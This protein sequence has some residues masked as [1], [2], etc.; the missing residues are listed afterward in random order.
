M[1]NLNSGITDRRHTASTDYT[2]S[3]ETSTQKI[4]VG[5][6]VLSTTDQEADNVRKDI[7]PTKLQDA[8]VLQRE[9]VKADFIDIDTSKAPEE[10]DDDIERLM[11]EIAL[12]EEQEQLEEEGLKSD[13]AEVDSENKMNA[14]ENQLT[15]VAEDQMETNQAIED[16]SKIS[17][18]MIEASDA[19]IEASD[20]LIEAQFN[21]ILNDVGKDQ[22]STLYLSHDK[23]SY[24]DFEA[25]CDVLG[26]DAKQIMENMCKEGH[27]ILTNPTT[28]DLLI[29]AHMKEMTKNAT[30]IFRKGSPTVDITKDMIH[31]VKLSP[32]KL[33]EFKAK[34][35]AGIQIAFKSQRIETPITPQRE[36]KKTKHADDS[37]NE[38]KQRE[39]LD[40]KADANQSAQKTEKVRYV[41]VPD[42]GSDSIRIMMEWFKN[43]EKK[44]DEEHDKLSQIFQ[45]YALKQ[46]A[47]KD[48]YKKGDSLVT[49]R[50]SD[51]LKIS[52]KELQQD[53]EEA[54]R[55][56]LDKLHEKEFEALANKSLSGKERTFVREKFRTI[57]T[58][59]TEVHYETKPKIN[60]PEGI[61]KERLLHTYF[62]TI[63][64]IVVQTAGMKT[65]STQVPQS[66]QLGG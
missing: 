13:L 63:S 28:G 1:D 16:D 19:L 4:Q 55:I 12:M 21:E 7:L 11:A 3:A 38:V 33:E 57:R 15:S 48:D 65:P 37:I 29:P 23:T 26:E 35:T 43:S 8:N 46:E 53:F 17:D 62:E 10:L 49:E 39:S 41:D 45:K 18:A 25:M 24:F 50:K 36:E 54:N 40:K 60:D 61:E 14:T 44:H 9:N 5:K 52:N 51:D 56:I 20:A 42:L 22:K 2:A 58:K 47:Q 30:K 59:I 27:V 66:G 34:L 64:T 32:E 6:P 31:Y